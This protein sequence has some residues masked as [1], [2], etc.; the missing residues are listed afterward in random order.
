MYKCPRHPWAYCIDE[1]GETCVLCEQFHKRKE[2]ESQKE[3]RLIQEA[4]VAAALASRAGTCKTGKAEWGNKLPTAGKL[5]RTAANKARE[6]S[7]ASINGG[8]QNRKGEKPGRGPK[9]QS[10]RIMRQRQISRT[11]RPQTLSRTKQRGSRSSGSSE[12][13]KNGQ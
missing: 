2:M 8:C 12:G 6:D 7:K 10:C 5:A 13:D 3:N 4:N 9:E 11:T 1:D